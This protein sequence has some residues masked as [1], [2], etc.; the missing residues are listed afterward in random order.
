M[1]GSPAIDKG[2]SFGLT[3]DQRGLTRPVDNPSI[4]NAGDGADIGAFEVRTDNLQ[5]DLTVVKSHTGNFTQGDTGKTYSIAVTNSGSAATNGTV[6]ITD[7]LP[8]GLT[9]TGI[10]GTGWNCTLNTLVCTRSDALAGGSSYPAIT[11]TVNVASNAPTGVTN[12]V[13]VSGGG[14]TNTANNTAGDPTTINAT[15]RYSISGAVSYGTTPT[16]QTV[17]SVAGVS[18]SATGASSTTGSTASSGAYTLSNLLSGGNYTV[19]PSKTGDVNGISSFD[20]SLV[21]RRVAGL[22]TLTPN[23][24]IAADVSNNGSVSSF[25][26]SLIAR[27]AAG[28]PNTG[29][30]GQW[31]F[32]PPSLSYPSLTANQTSQNYEAILMGEVSGNWT[33]PTP[34]AN[35]LEYASEKALTAEDQA[36]ADRVEEQVYY[37]TQKQF[38]LP[39]TMWQTTDQPLKQLPTKSNGQ[40][41]DA[42]QATINVTLPANTTASNGTAV[43]IPVTVGDTTGQQIFSFDFTVTFNQAILTPTTCSAATNSN[44]LSA[45]AGFTIT[46][47]PG[48]GSV[49]ISGF[50]SQ[51]LSGAGTL[52]NLCFN[53]VGTSGTASGMTNLA[54]TSFVF[55]EGDP[56]ANPSGGTF[57]VTGPTAAGVGVGG[58]VTTLQGNGISWAVVSLTDATGAVRT[59]MTNES[60]YYRFEEVEAGGTYVIGVRAKRYSFNQAAQVKSINDE[61]TDVNFIGYSDRKTGKGIR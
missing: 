42:A 57:R 34:S 17:K 10:G 22:I 20:A 60:G 7:T 51:A 18:M 54:F 15:P 43:V 25:D 21:A 39:E 29:V 36:E 28:I 56:A 19:T 33:A 40:T 27:T 59:T 5:P 1:T 9:A 16:G 6:G 4:T 26:A 52:V 58:R 37:E 49:T 48:T 24:M 38:G 55:N 35:G 50:G 61:A 41:L 8:G 47:S 32:S 53:V 44:T 14:E 46:T 12:I 31:R 3:T 11:L 2:S 45:T 13:T 30:A 23:Q